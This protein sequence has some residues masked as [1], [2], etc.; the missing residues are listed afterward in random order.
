MGTDGEEPAADHQPAGG[1][2]AAGGRRRGW[3][4]TAVPVTRL[5]VVLAL[6]VV[7]VVVTTVV[8][9]VAGPPSEDD[10]RQQ[11]GLIGKHELLVGVKDDQ[12]GVALRD[13]ATGEYHGFDID[14]ARMVAADLGFRPSEVRFVPL[15]SEDRNRMEANVDGRVV[16]VDMVV[17]SYSI[18]PARIAAGARFSAPYLRT[19]QSVVTRADHARVESLSD[20]ARESV[21][22]ISTSTTEASLARAGITDRHLE[23]KISGCI[24]GL[25]A[26]RYDAVTTDAAL[27]AGFVHDP[28]NRGRLTHYDIGD[29][30][31]ENWGI[32][33]GSNTALQTL[34]NLSLYH[35]W[36]DPDDQR[37]E[38]AYDD[39][40][41]VEQPDSRNQIVASDRQPPVERPAV[42]Q[43]PWQR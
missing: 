36:H 5:V 31:Q 21:C 12:P 26:K 16:D 41:R 32:N 14:I 40:L 4:R 28:A 22:A 18:T 17:A 38:R 11:A 23:K 43:W 37:W 34:V 30:S 9:V 35:S 2:H 13:P 29:E 27:L 20:L 1:A 33:V 19:E 15:E 7:A 10:L 24:G 8:A 3:W 39:N 6:I 42:R 25:L